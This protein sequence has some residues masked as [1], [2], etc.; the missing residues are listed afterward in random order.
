LP[1]AIELVISLNTNTACA[2][3]HFVKLQPDWAVLG[4]LL[5]RA[6]PGS[7][8]YPQ[9]MD[10]LWGGGR[11]KEPEDPNGTMRTQISKLRKCLQPL[12]YGIVP[13]WHEGYRLVDQ[14]AQEAVA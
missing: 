9:I 4:D 1:V 2:R 5:L 3:G 7:V 14:A 11:F 12:G 13:I 10:A 6:W 8:T